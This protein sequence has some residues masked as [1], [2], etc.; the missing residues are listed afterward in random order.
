MQ[1]PYRHVVI[2]SYDVSRVES[3]HTKRERH[4]LSGALGRPSDGRRRCE[5][6]SI[7][8]ATTRREVESAT[9]ELLVVLICGRFPEAR[10]MQPGRCR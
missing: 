3:C 5:Q 7:H 10:R 8:V 6:S 9:V 2:G 1:S 4:I